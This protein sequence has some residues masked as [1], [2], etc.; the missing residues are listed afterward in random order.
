MI[1]TN[2]GRETTKTSLGF[3]VAEGE[4]ANLTPQSAGAAAI[5]FFLKKV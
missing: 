5:L 2:P 1:I 3:A 4:F